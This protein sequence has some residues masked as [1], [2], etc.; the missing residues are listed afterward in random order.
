[1]GKLIGNN[2]LIHESPGLNLDW[3]GEVRLL[4]SPCINQLQCISHNIY[5]SF[6][7]GPETRAVSLDISKAFNKFWHRGLFYNLKQNGI[8]GDLLNPF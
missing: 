4:G 3:F 8:S 6:D 2:W 1:M 5:Q 7:D